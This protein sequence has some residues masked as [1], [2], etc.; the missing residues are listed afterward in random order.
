MKKVYAIGESL[1]DIIF[2]NGDV[3]AAKAGGS[4]LNSAISLGRARQ[5]IVF[6]SEFGQDQGGNFISDFLEQ[7]HVRT[8][9]IHRYK[10]GKTPIALAFLN[11][12][13]DAS[14]DFYKPYPPKRLQLDVPQFTPDDVFLFGSFFGIDPS[15]RET[16][17]SIVRSARDHGALIVYDPNFRKPH[18]HELEKLRPFIL[19][20]IEL[21]SI[22]KASNEDMELIFGESDPKNL[23]KIKQLSDK[24]LFITQGSSGALLDTTGYSCFY[25][26]QK[27]EVVSTIGAGDNFNAGLI[28]G[29]INQHV[30]HHNISLVNSEQWA[31]IAG[32]AMG[33]AANV[34]LSYDNY[35]SQ[36]YASQLP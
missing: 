5:D 11:E 18:A 32:Y 28:Y 2:S 22:V 12:K 29:L 13:G 27:I 4:M 23:R 33:F 6:L 3:K 21:A 10:D 16:L 20:N 19:E 8:D 36:E 7:N 34:C 26:A 17:L 30:A 9:L 35:I 1:I 15:I 24:P 31:I 14:Y 25:P